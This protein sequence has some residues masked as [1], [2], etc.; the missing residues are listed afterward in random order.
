M[1]IYREMKYYPYPRTIM[2]DSGLCYNYKYYIMNLGTHPTAYVQIPF[3]HPYYGKSYE[4]IDIDVHGGLTY[5]EDYLNLE[6][7]KIINCWFIGW[8]YAHY[9]DYSGY[10]ELIPNGLKVGGKKWTTEE[11][12][13]DVMKVCRQLKDIENKEKYSKKEE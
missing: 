4:D 5:S 2:L 1:N 3:I 7:E 9:G 13:E 11:I 10:E 12:R 8:D 6:N